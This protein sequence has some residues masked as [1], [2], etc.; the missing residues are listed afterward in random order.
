MKTLCVELD[1]LS[2]QLL[3]R[4][5]AALGKGQTELVRELILYYLQDVENLRQTSDALA[6]LEQLSGIGLKKVMG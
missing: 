2:L 3:G 1:D 5:A 6:R 4:M